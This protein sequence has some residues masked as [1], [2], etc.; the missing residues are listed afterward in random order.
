MGAVMSD[1]SSDVMRTK[2]RALLAT[3][4]ITVARGSSRAG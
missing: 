4:G 3:K 1:I 2:V